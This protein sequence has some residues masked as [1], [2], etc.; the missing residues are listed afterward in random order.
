[1]FGTLGDYAWVWKGAGV[2]TPSR[3]SF[4]VSSTNTQGNT[5]DSSLLSPSPPP[6]SLSRLCHQGQSEV[7]APLSLT[8][9]LNPRGPFSSPELSQLNKRSGPGLVSLFLHPQRAFTNFSLSP[10]QVYFL[11]QCRPSA[12][13]FGCLFLSHRISGGAFSP[14]TSLR[15][16]GPHSGFL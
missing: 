6:N 10:A 3:S 15:A 7:T 13:Q 16:R 1:M 9:H 14:E 11:P 4:S 2:I 8:T 12:W 5:G